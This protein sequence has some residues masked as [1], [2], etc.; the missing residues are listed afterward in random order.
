MPRRKFYFVSREKNNVD[1]PTAN[2]N[3]ARG[4]KNYSG[5][6]GKNLSFDAFRKIPGAQ[7]SKSIAIVATSIRWEN[8]RSR[9]SISA[10]LESSPMT[11]PVPCMRF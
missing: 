10:I 3:L 2:L 8:I 9:P 4:C 7:E 5:D 6:M 1:A 11:R